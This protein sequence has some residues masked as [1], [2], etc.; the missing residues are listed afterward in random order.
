VQVIL[1][2]ITLSQETV[3]CGTVTFVVTNTDGSVIHDFNVWV[4]T[5]VK[6]GVFGPRLRPGKTASTTVSFPFKGV[7]D[8]F[9]RGPH[10]DDYGET[11]SLTVV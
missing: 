3:R 6:G 7:V 8:Y 9:C 4:P 11:G 5:D 1:G 10:H 2:S